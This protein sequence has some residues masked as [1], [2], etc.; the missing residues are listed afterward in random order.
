M[1]KNPF[2]PIVLSEDI[3]AKVKEEDE[4]K[5]VDAKRYWIR[6][7]IGESSDIRYVDGG[8]DDIGSIM[9]RQQQRESV[10]GTA[11]MPESNY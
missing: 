5:E 11:L 9:M 10:G 1:I 4:K 3:K 2:T 6:Y 7:K 8:E